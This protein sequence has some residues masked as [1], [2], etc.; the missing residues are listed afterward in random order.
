MSKHLTGVMIVALAA[1]TFFTA[2]AFADHRPGNVVVMGGT[3]SLT[4]KSPASRL[5]S[6]PWPQGSCSKGA[7]S[8]SRN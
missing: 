1:A 4:A 6:A 5:I 2:P 3:L 7:K 8:M